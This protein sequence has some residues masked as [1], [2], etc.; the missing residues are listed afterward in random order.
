[1]V[2]PAPDDIGGI[3]CGLDGGVVAI[4]PPI[5]NEVM[6]DVNI[7]FLRSFVVLV[8]ERN[9]AKAGRR[10]GIPQS[11]VRDHIAALEE[12]VGKRLLE[13]RF[14]T[15][16]AETGRTQLTEDGRA[17]L[18]KAIEVMRAY[19]R[20][21]DDIP[22]GVDQREHNRAIALGLMEMA[23]AALKH[24]LSDEDQKRIGNLLS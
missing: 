14:P 17:F 3:T 16:Q 12:A 13:R 11:R 22:V 24:D 23:L 18:P 4:R 10:L 1:M 9:S 8:E 2:V 21:F 7:K 20:M 5:F 19:N 15:E 6:R